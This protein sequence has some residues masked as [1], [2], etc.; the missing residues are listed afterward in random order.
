MKNKLYTK[1][2]LKVANKHNIK[3]E[4]MPAPHPSAFFSSA[5]EIIDLFYFSSLYQTNFVIVNSQFLLDGQPGLKRL[6]HGKQNK[7]IYYLLTCV[8]CH[9]IDST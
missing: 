3:F 9:G 8:V 6:R 5:Q 2:A 1:K 4:S 7:K